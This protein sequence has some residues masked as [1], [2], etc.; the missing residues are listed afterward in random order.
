MNTLL[1]S[2]EKLWDKDALFILLIGS[3]ILIEIMAIFIKRYIKK[4]IFAIQKDLN[5]DNENPEYYLE[6]YRKW[7]IIDIIR[8]SV[9]FVAI[10]TLIVTRTSIGA[11]FFVVVAG[12]LVITFRDFILSIVAFFIILR[13]YKIGETIG[14][15]D[16]Q[17][18]IISIRM[19][20][21]W[22]LGKDNDGDNTGRHFTIPGYK[23]L[24]ETIRREELQVES[25]RKE[26]IRIPYSHESYSIG[27]NQFNKELKNLLNTILP[28]ITKKNCGNFQTY[29]GYKYKLDVDYYE[30]KCITITVWII[31]KWRKNVERK[32]Q[33]VEWAEQFRLEKNDRH[34]NDI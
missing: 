34:H 6:Y 24:T 10:G 5:S 20:T 15:G 18:Q 25:I 13:R 8:F 1:N 29:I 22:L 32:E 2:I 26:L 27:F 33:I 3:I 9:F 4:Q 17:W 28:M 12:A 19:F 16:I 30:D 23:F 21:V 31:W 11:S 7:Q 14:I